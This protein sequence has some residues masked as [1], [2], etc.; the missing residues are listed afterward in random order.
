MDRHRKESEENGKTKECIKCPIYRLPPTPHK[1][2]Q[3]E[4]SEVD[5]GAKI[6]GYAGGGGAVVV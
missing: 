1:D 6:Q 5:P 3:R 2:A 4:Q